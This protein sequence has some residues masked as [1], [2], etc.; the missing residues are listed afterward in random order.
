MI[1]LILRR[2]PEVDIEEKEAPGW[3]GFRPASVE[4]LLE[5]FRVDEPFVVGLR[6]TDRVSSAA[7]SPQ[8]A[9]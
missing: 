5:P 2:N 6:S 9:S 3:G 4:Q 8:P 7:H 1:L